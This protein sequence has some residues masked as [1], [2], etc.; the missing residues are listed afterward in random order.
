MTD[1]ASL[2]EVVLP[3]VKSFYNG[4]PTSKVLWD[5]RKA[6]GRRGVTRDI[7]EILLYA[8]DHGQKRASGK[9]AIVSASIL[10]FGLSRTAEILS[11]ILEL[12]WEI[13]GF[14]SMKEAVAW[15]EVSCPEELISQIRQ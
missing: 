7:E 14:Q 13:K 10:D 15:L 2:A 8:K 11:H 9:T 6:E 5:F 1:T 3:A 4:K 12:P